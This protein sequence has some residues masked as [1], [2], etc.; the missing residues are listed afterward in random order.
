MGKPKKKSGAKKAADAK[1]PEEKPVER[2]EGAREAVGDAA[3]DSTKDTDVQLAGKEQDAQNG[4]SNGEASRDGAKQEAAKDTAENG[5]QQKRVDELEKR[6]AEL[7]QDNAR[8]KKEAT[9]LEQETAKLRIQ[10]KS[11]DEYEKLKK[12]H[13]KLVE[14]HKDYEDIKKENARLMDVQKGYDEL[15]AKLEKE[16]ADNRD[17]R[18]REGQGSESASADHQKALDELKTALQ[19]AQEERDDAEERYKGLREKV[20]HIRTTLGERLRADAQELEAAREE[21]DVLNGD[22]ERLQK[23]IE[24]LQSEAVSANDES[25]RLSRELSA[26]RA[27]LRDSASR[28]STERD[29]LLAEKK[30]VVD[31]REKIR[32][33]EVAMAEERAARES[34]VAS[35]ASLEEQVSV[36]TTYAERFRTE[37][38]GLRQELETLRAARDKENVALGEQIAALETKLKETNDTL[39]AVHQELATARSR[40][41]EAEEQAKR[42]PQLEAETKEKNL[43]IGKLRHEAVILNEHLTKSLRMIRKNS[44]GETV[45]KE[46][47][48]NLIIS[49]LTIP[50]GDAKKFEVLQLIAGFL[51]WDDE[52]RVQAGLSR[53]SGAT[54]AAMSPRLGNSRAGSSTN[55]A[56]ADGSGSVSS[57]MGLF[58]EF[59]ERESNK[60]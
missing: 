32:L 48:S 54:S 28:W 56:E 25:S 2:V 12:E 45:D 8:L 37:R 24:A 39:A 57:V 51:A 30:H 41:A 59:L 21:I 53:P 14:D 9:G 43:L 31:A 26:L 52:Q 36:Q 60:K 15:K 40:A 18:M 35:S 58:A 44:E 20:S 33:L 34:A 50:R 11:Q 29:E 7:E 38:D 13:A 27:E 6:C 16:Q 19:A 47:I 49:F 22:K 1:A 55:L 17:L 10:D 3:G 5:D 4:G 46:L 42:V 23:Q